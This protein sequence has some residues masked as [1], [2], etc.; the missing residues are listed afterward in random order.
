M[1]NE[2]HS[3]LKRNPFYIASKNK[4]EQ[5]SNKKEKQAPKTNPFYIPKTNPINNNNIN[6]F[7]ISSKSDQANQQN[8]NINN[9][10]FEDIKDPLSNLV[11]TNTIVPEQPKEA[12]KEKK[13]ENKNKEWGNINMDPLASAKVVETVVQS[14]E[15]KEK[16]NNN[17]EQLASRNNPFYSPNPNPFDNDFNA[18]SNKNQPQINNN[19]IQQQPNNVKFEDIKDPL[20]NL[21]ETN[22][23]VSEQPKEVKNEVKEENKNKEWGNIN[24]DPLASAKVVETIVQSEDNKQEKNEAKPESK[25]NPFSSSNSNPFNNNSFNASKNTAQ[26]IDNNSIK[27]KNK[28]NIKFEDIEDPLNNLVETNTIVSEQPKEVKKE[29]KEENK[30]KEWG[31]VNMDPFAS[32]KVVETIV[33]SS[34][35]KQENQNIKFEGIKDP[36]ASLIETNT[37]VSEKPKEP[38][39]NMNTQQNNKEWG[40]VNMDPFAGAKVV[41]TIVQSSDIKQEDNKEN[42]KK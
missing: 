39:N 30:N 33:Q 32:A 28:E 21:I 7:N 18:S 12:K 24:M 6:N 20:A 14:E 23:I 38:Q 37:I 25:I 5:T 11:E 4:N 2:N 9:I 34:N 31:N 42:D 27:E 40:N 17:E 36:L 15:N 41:E 19:N 16:T 13:E 35:T 29:M 1:P 3:E 10:K 8:N 26:T 22:T